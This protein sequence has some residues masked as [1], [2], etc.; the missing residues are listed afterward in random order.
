MPEYLL[1]VI[2][3]N[4]RAQYVNDI[5]RAADDAENL[6]K[7]LGATFQCIQKAGLKLTIH[8]CYFWATV[9]DYRGGTIT[10]DGVKPQ[11]QRVQKFLETINSQVQKSTATKPGIRELLQQLYTQAFR[12]MNTV[13][14][15]VWQ[16]DEKV[17]ITLDLLN[18]FIAINRAPDR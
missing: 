7:C 4:K 15:R 18:K 9:I 1:E 2:K 13:F 5:G 8:E 3:A 16:K 12:K 6:I 10:P 11:R 17:P 14:F